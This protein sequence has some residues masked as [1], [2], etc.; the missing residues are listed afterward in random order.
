MTSTEPTAT[1]SP[2]TAAVTALPAGFVIRPAADA[3]GDLFV[4]LLGAC[5][6]EYDAMVFDPDDEMAHLRR[7]ASHYGDAGG[8][9]LVVEHADPDSAAAADVVAG[10][11]AWRPA[12]RPGHV[13]LQLLYVMPAARRRGL[14]THLVARVEK[15]AQARGHTTVELWSDTRFVDAHRLYG[16]IGYT[17]L[18]WSRLLDDLSASTEYHFE[19]RLP[20]RHPVG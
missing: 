14:A 4:A 9:V 18:A 11:V 10:S 5:W 13:E 7:V 19:K 3:D 12:T 17:R 1:G 2:T 20:A 16:A 6:G 15:A 8:E